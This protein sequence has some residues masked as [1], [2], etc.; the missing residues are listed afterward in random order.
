MNPATDPKAHHC[1][2]ACRSAIFRVRLVAATERADRKLY[3]SR[4]TYAPN[5]IA[6]IQCR[7]VLLAI[8]FAPSF[9]ITMIQKTWLAKNKQTKTRKNACRPMAPHTKN[10]LKDV[11][12]CAKLS[13]AD[14]S[15]PCWLLDFKTKFP[16]G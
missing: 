1:T 9:P 4:K 8:S 2:G 11:C 12:S 14:G 3:A 5:P 15:I 10:Y 16:Y 7:R 13:R 6:P